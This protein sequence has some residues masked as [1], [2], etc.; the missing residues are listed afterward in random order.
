MT[1]KKSYN[2]NFSENLNHLLKEKNLSLNQVSKGTHINKSTLHNYLNGV[3][4]QGLL[5]IIKISRFFNISVEELIF[6]IN[7]HPS[8]PLHLNYE[9]N[10]EITIKKIKK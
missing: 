4:P 2:I 5:P 3:L 10:Y 9:G 8:S 1:F 6:E 7:K